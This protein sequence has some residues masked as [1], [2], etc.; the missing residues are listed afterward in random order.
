[1]ASAPASLITAR[2]A[3]S[4]LST[5]QPAWRYFLYVR[6]SSEPDDRQVLS[7]ESQKKELLQMFGH[8]PIVETIEEAHSAKAPGRPCFEKM[9]E[10]I[11]HGEA[12]GIIAW[13]PDR[14]ARNS[15]DGGRVIY[16]LDRGRVQD[17]KFAGYTFENTPEGKWMLNIIFG[18]SKYFVDKLS[19][20]VKRGQ[21][22]KLQLG[23]M[24]ARAPLGYRNTHDLD[25]GQHIIVPDPQRFELIKK[26]WDLMLTGSYSAAR[27][28]QIANE[29]WGFLTPRHANS[30]DKPLSYSGIYRIFNNPFYYGWFGYNG[31]LYEGKH[32]AM[33]TE[34]EFWQVQHLL[35]KKGRARPKEKLFAYTG[36][37]RCGE[38]GAMVTAEE[39]Y[40][41]IK[42]EGVLRRY[43]YYHC[44]GRRKLHLSGKP[45]TSCRQPS[46]EVQ[47][48]ER[49][50]NG[51]LEPMSIEEDFLNWGVK[52]LQE[53]SEQEVVS[54]RTVFASV[55]SAY[56]STQKQLDELLSLRLKGLIDDEMFDTRRVLLQKE[57]NRLKARLDDTENR[58]DRWIEL[59]ENVLHFSFLLVSR[60]NAASVD[61][62][63]VILETI[64][65]NWVL[66][67]KKLAFEPVA[68]YKFMKKT[69]KIS[70]WQDIVKQVRTFYL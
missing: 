43:E 58:A 47:E 37:I 50:M 32:P 16:D 6:K 64:G 56:E 21:R 8:L 12:N 29:E 14:L 67:D 53:L 20:D 60:F 2:N 38:C 63:R 51:I 5:P 10:R 9:L 70:V 35:G 23:W 42:K 11:E 33:V 45:N 62:K 61:E 69:S 44:T 17:L 65:S 49:Q 26:M 7:I 52:Y 40:K 25:T 39:K 41:I 28:L 68:P 54:R 48:L 30:G 15:V 24:P 46:I 31:T 57:R 34:A 55:Q 18:Q 1:M 59:A 13:H 66:R 27:V 22:A 36:F 3:A 19:K 4:P